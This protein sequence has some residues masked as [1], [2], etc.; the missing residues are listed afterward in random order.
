MTAQILCP[1]C[2]SPAEPSPASQ[3]IELIECPE[4]LRIWEAE[5]HQ[6]LWD[7]YQI[8][9]EKKEGSMN[10][11]RCIRVCYFNHRLWSIGEIYAA[12]S[13]PNK[14]NFELQEGTEPVEEDKSKKKKG[15]NDGQVEGINL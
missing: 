6:R 1:F 12:E 7:K 10:K 11:Y 9:G 5:H 15:G 14:K 8:R 13:N 3:E 4:C 2:L